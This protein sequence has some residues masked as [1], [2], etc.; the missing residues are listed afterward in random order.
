MFVLTIDI[1]GS[2]ATETPANLAEFMQKNSYTFPV[3]LDDKLAMTRAYGVKSTPTNFILDKDGVIRTKL[4][5]AFPD[6][7]TLDE[8][9]KQAS[10]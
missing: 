5:G 2:R 10:K 4:T 8:L 3:L 9:I 6:Q 7:A 1:I